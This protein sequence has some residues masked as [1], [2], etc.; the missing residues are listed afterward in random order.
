M[1]RIISMIFDSQKSGRHQLLCLSLFVLVTTALFNI[2][3]NPLVLAAQC[4]ELQNQEDLLDRGDIAELFEFGSGIFAAILFA[5]S[6]IAYKN[7][8]SKRLVIVAI[9]FGLIAIRTIL[10]RLDLF[11]RDRVITA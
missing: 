3:W 4:D 7:M 5:L 2:L 6:L 9:A 8:K 1:K 10:L 11:V